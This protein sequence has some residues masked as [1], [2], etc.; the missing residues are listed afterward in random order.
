ME[1]YKQDGNLNILKYLFNKL[2]ENYEPTHVQ[3][4]SSRVQH[5]ELDAATLPLSSSRRSF[6]RARWPWRRLFRCSSVF[7][8]VSVGLRLNVQFR[9][10]SSM[11]GVG[12]MAFVKMS[13]SWC[14][15]GTQCRAIL[16]S[17]R[18][19]RATSRSIKV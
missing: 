15:V 17:S 7:S 8:S 1:W 18:R 19:S 6:R 4:L 3:L 12:S 5:C 10:N 16:F 13:A 14:V 9:R 2:S 11:T